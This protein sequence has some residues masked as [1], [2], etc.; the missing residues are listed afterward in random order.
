MRKLFCLA[1]LLQQSQK[2][3]KICFVN[4][5]LCFRMIWRKFQNAPVCIIFPSLS[6]IYFYII[7][8]LYFHI[9]DNVTKQWV[10]TEFNGFSWRQYQGLRK[11]FSCFG[12]LRIIIYKV[13]DGSVNVSPCG[14]PLGDPHRSRFCKRSHFY[15]RMKFC[16]K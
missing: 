15:I 1:E 10:I 3:C 13:L 11:F 8:Q 4:Q 2:A 16:N 6:F 7:G 9:K 5:F 12:L 14:F